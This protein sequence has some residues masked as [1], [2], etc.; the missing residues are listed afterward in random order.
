MTRMDHVWTYDLH[1]HQVIAE[2]SGPLQ[3]HEIMRYAL[4]R[5]FAVKM[6]SV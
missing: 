3:S 5:G 4:Q 6:Q 2:N 1:R